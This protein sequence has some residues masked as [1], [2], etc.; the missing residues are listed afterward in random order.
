MT[1]TQTYE[2]APQ[3]NFVEDED[4]D[5][6]VGLT[7]TQE[8]AD[9]AG[10][11]EDEEEIDWGSLTDGAPKPGVQS[12]FPEST[13]SKEEC[14]DCDGDC[15]ECAKKKRRKLI[16]IGS[17]ICISILAMIIIFAKKK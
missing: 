15:E 10:F 12:S 11:E 13:E 6:F 7:E 4:E 16:I 17:A 14:E 1:Q 5:V 3:D 8:L 9:D 2:L